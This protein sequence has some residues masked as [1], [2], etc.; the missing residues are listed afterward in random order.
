MR[1]DKKRIAH[2]FPLSFFLARRVSHTLR[3]TH[4]TFPPPVKRPLSPQVTIRGYKK[5]GYGISEDNFC[6]RV[7]QAGALASWVPMAVST[8]P[9][10]GRC[11][12]QN[13]TQPESDVFFLGDR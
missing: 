7:R 6:G 9:I 13:K 11:I 2:T 3:R 12:A 10:S 5:I 4:I 8:G 1:R